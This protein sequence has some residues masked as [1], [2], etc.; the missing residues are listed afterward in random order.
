MAEEKRLDPLCHRGYN[1]PGFLGGFFVAKPG[2]KKR[3]R[4]RIT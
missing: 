4:Q 2:N 3:G 1:F